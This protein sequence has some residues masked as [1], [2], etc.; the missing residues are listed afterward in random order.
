MFDEARFSG[1][2]INFNSTQFQEAS[3]LNAQ[4]KTTT[5]L[6]VAFGAKF[7]GITKFD[8]T[9]FLSDVWF[10][11]AE[12]ASTASFNGAD[13]SGQ[14]GFD[15]VK[16]PWGADFS[17]AKFNRGARFHRTQFN[18][19][20]RFVRSEFSGN[21]WFDE[22]EFFLEGD[23]KREFG[24]RVE[25]QFNAAKFKG[26]GKLGPLLTSNLLVLDDA[27]FEGVTEIT[28]ASLQISSARVSFND[29][30]IF[31]TRFAE[32]V[33]DEA[34]FAR[35]SV[36]AFARDELLNECH[37]RHNGQPSKPRILS[38]RQVD[39]STLTLIDIDLSA[40]LFQDAHNLDKLRIHGP[41]T[42][43]DSPGALAATR[44]TTMDSDLA[45]MEP[46]TD[47]G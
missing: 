11:Y 33:L 21:R 35:P 2:Q 1:R 24:G 36:F 12:F 10:N 44:W 46:T 25:T 5:V 14:A 38:L 27:T 37:I 42:F 32:I 16:F 23:A 28:I 40:C 20:A 31:R 41:R 19:P 3:F 17:R 34:R 13:F 43:A 22:T 26:G 4:F 18:G 7:G 15:K 47:L 30:L 39:V 45:A 9:L 29:Q 8:G 6:G